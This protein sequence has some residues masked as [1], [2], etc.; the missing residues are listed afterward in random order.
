MGFQT[1]LGPARFGTSKEGAG[2]NCGLPVLSQSNTLA[3]TDT[4][5]KN[6]CILP[7]GAQIISIIL[8]VTTVFNAGDTNVIDIGTTADGA[9]YVNDAA[10]GTAVHAVCTLVAANLAS[11]I[12]VGSSDVQITATYVPGGTAAGTGAATVTVNYVMR[13]PDGTVTH[14]P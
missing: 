9:L 12:N 6:I 5:A 1:H 7:A 2:F 8:D 13:N 14:N 10:A 4:A 11:V 3:Y